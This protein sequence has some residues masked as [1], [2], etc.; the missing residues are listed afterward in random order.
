MSTKRYAYSVDEE[1]FEGD[2]ASREDALAEARADYDREPCRTIY[3]GVLAPAKP[4]RF[5]EYDVDMLIERKQEQAYEE[6]GECSDGWPT[7]TTDQ[8][9][10]L[11]K[12]LDEVFQAW[13]TETGQ[14]PTWFNIV[15]T[16]AHEAPSCED[17]K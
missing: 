6:V 3:T 12:R 9:D 4:V 7:A 1:R 14:H 5:G 10:D 16:Q 8:V 11:R 15:E 17:P 2:F 13:L